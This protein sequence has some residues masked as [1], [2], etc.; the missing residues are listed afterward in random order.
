MKSRVVHLFILRSTGDCPTLATA[1]LPRYS[2]TPSPSLF[3][4]HGHRSGALWLHLSSML[5]LRRCG[6]AGGQSTFHCRPKRQSPGFGQKHRPA[7]G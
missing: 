6:R 4:R 2:Q 7:S 3:R 1:T 5:W